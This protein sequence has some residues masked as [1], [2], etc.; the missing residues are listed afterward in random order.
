[1]G[2][3]CTTSADR[4]FSEQLAFYSGTEKIGY[5]ILDF[6]YKLLKLFFLALLWRS[7]ISTHPFYRRISLGPYNETLRDMILAN[8]PGHP[9]KFAI[10]LAKFSD[11]ELKGMLDPH[12]EKIEG[13]NYC[14]FYLTG[15][16]AYI[17]V[18][19][20]SPPKYFRSFMITENPPITVILRKL[21][22]SKD[23]T[24]MKEIV[25]KSVEK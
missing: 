8:D 20:R 5:R 14:R 17:K 21:H 11:P 22:G 2:Q 9:E 4:M 12:A 1:M 16:V 15:F 10:T 25:R 23:G 24:I 6:D 3:P 19:R 13:V 7:S 18:D